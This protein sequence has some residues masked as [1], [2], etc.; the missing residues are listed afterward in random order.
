MPASMIAALRAVSVSVTH[1]P[2]VENTRSAILAAAA[3]VKMMQRI[4]SGGT[5]V[6]SS[7][8]TRCTSTWV[9]P[10][11]AFAETNDDEP[12]FEALAC[13]ARTAGGMGRTDFTIRAVPDR[14]R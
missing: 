3:L 12:G 6:S 5:P 11:P 1:W 9:L 2:R 13:L 8:I 10:E 7:R 4:F 14:R